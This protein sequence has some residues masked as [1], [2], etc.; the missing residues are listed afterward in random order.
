MMLRHTFA[1]GAEADAVESAVGAVLASGL[2]TADLGGAASCVEMGEAVVF[3][4]TGEG[5]KE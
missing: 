4:L 5:Q 2:R 1:L 3:A